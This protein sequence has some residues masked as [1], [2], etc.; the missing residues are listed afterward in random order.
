LTSEDAYLSLRR[1]RPNVDLQ[2]NHV[3]DASG[4][5][6]DVCDGLVSIDTA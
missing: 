1:Y 5:I 2:L 3:C 4:H 6:L